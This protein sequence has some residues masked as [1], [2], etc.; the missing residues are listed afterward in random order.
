MKNDLHK[1]DEYPFPKISLVTITDLIV[2]VYKEKSS[3]PPDGE[4]ELNST[5]INTHL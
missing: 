4:Q 5:T 2:S 1:E 3:H